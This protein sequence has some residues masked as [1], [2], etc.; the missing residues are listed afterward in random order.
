MR[1]LGLDLKVGHWI[2]SWTQNLDVVLKMKLN[3]KDK[4]FVI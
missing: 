4:E 2:K 3:L 1:T